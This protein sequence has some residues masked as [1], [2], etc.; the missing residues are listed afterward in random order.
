MIY[1]DPVLLWLN[2]ARA[3]ALPEPEHPPVPFTV[4]RSEVRVTDQGARVYIFYAVIPAER[5]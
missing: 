4:T 2:E 1:R 3:F 5:A